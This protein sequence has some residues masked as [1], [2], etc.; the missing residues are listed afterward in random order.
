VQLA[1][2]QTAV[3]VGIGAHAPRPARHQRG[4]LGP[5]ATVLVK[6]LCGPVAAQPV[7]QQFQMPRVISRVQG[8]LVRP[9]IALDGFTVDLLRPRPALGRIEHD[10]R[11][12]SALGLPVLA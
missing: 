9:E 2:Q 12:A 3:G 5:Q 10:H 6:Q 11:P 1:Q 7:L 4:Q 8:Y